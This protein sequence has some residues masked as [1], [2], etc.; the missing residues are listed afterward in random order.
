MTDELNVKK[1]IV[2]LFVTVNCRGFT[3]NKHFF[4]TTGKLPVLGHNNYYTN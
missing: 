2:Q 4:I 1:N 3:V